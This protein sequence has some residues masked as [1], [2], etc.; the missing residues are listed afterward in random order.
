MAICTRCY[1]KD[2]SSPPK[3]SVLSQYHNTNTSNTSKIQYYLMLNKTE[4]L[5]KSGFFSSEGK[6]LKKI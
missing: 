4:L 3:K 1:L 5:N 2:Q 6:M